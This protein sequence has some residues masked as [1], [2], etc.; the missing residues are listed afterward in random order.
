MADMFDYSDYFPW[1]CNLNWFGTA[2]K[3]RG[4]VMKTVDAIYY[5]TTFA[6]PLGGWQ[7]RGVRMLYLMRARFYFEFRH[8]LEHPEAYG[9]N[10]TL[11]YDFFNQEPR[12]G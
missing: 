2:W 9:G 4:I 5:L 8:E 6:V 1:R 7:W 12:N 10:E 3:P 11:G